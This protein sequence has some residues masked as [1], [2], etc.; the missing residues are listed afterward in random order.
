MFY[1]QKSNQVN[2]LCVLEKNVHSADV[3]AGGSINVI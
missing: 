3:G 1:S 2:V